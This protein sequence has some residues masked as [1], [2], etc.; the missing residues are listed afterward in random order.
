MNVQGI[1]V[2]VKDVIRTP[3]TFFT[4]IEKEVG[5]KDPFFYA[6]VFLVI[7]SLF[8]LFYYNSY[9]PFVLAVESVSFVSIL[10]LVFLIFLPLQLG[11]LFGGAGLSFLFLK[12][13]KG[14]GTYVETFR[15]LVYAATPSFLLGPLFMIYAALVGPTNT[16]ALLI[17]NIV[18][19]PLAIYVIYLAV[20][21]ISLSHKIT[22]LKALLG[23]FILPYAAL[24]VLSLVFV[25]LF[26]LIAV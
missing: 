10:G 17:S 21:G 16:T 24:F 1:I 6:L 4:V 25:L 2:R 13:L 12:L 11:F 3:E 18:A 23:S 15:V 22:K 19:I 9:L 26:P 8:S 20:M 14:V 7:N 5:L